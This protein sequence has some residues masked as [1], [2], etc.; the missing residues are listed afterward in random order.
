MRQRARPL[1]WLTVALA[2]TFLLGLFR[3][4]PALELIYA[5]G[6]LFR[7]PVFHGDTYMPES[8]TF[9][10]LCREATGWGG[11]AGFWRVTSV[12]V[13]WIPLVLA[14]VAVAVNWRRALPW[15]AGLVLFAWLAMA[16][17]APL[18][19]F[20]CIWPLPILNAMG[21]PGK[22]FSCI[23][24][25]C[26]CVLAG[27]SIDALA[28]SR[29]PCVRRL[30]PA[31]LIGAGALFL[32]PKVWAV[33]DA[34]Y[35]GTIR[36]QAFAPSE[37]FFQ[38]HGLKPEL[39][40]GRVEP[41]SA[42]SYVNIRR[43][44]G[45]IDWCRSIKFSHKAICRYFVTANGQFLPNPEYRGECF[46]LESGQC[47]PREISSHRI[48]ADVDAER[49]GTLIVNQSHHRDWR[50]SH[51][52]LQEWEGLLAI[53]LPPGRY[54]LEL[55]YFSQSFAVGLG[56]SLACLLILSAT[57]VLYG[58]GRIERWSRSQTPWLRIP[59]RTFM[60]IVA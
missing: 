22:Y 28:R 37:E 8:Y 26:V 52:T 23:P 12:C 34:S 2:L 55:S 49:P 57:I 33:S 47:V 59:A 51:G 3:I 54:R 39:E 7:M 30:V 24:V 60:V 25:L 42:S 15:A 45:T 6:S 48:A 44:I 43:G 9:W 13:G 20:R 18:D 10:R 46:W 17:N 14:A 58:K 40:P 56:V 38:I 50:A 31:L 41:F 11:D 19:L 32:Y 5:N 1:R 27:Q 29:R 36:A 16:Q 53:R 35:T 21:D 4:L